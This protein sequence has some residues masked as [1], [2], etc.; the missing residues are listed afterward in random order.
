MY[1]G[2]RTGLYNL[3]KSESV[4]GLSFQ[5]C[6]TPKDA[7]RDIERVIAEICPFHYAIA[8]MQSS[9]SK[10]AALIRMTET[11]GCIVGQC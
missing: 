10:L 11:N 8:C 4:V 6:D 3:R 2:T 1:R 7:V 5:N 9:V